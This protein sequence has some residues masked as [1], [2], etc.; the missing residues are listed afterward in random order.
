MANISREQLEGFLD[1]AL[2]DLL[3]FRDSEGRVGIDQ[4]APK[5]EF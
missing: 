2:G 1:D 3:A 4:P 5:R